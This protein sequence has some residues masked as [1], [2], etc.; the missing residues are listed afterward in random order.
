MHLHF[1]LLVQGGSRE[2]TLGCI[3]TMGCNQLGTGGTLLFCK[4]GRR[5]RRGKGRE[6]NEGKWKEKKV[7]ER[8]REEG[9]EVEGGEGE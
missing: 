9:R 3:G 2:G 4:R 5:G 7:R 1:F 6:R 8:K